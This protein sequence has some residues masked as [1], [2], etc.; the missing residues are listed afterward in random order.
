MAYFRKQKY[1]S[2][3]EKISINLEISVILVNLVQLGNEIFMAK[4]R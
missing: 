4:S 1:L 3:F 2:K